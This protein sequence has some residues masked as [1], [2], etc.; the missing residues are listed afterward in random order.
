MITLQ[1]NEPFQH[2]F[3]LGLVVRKQNWRQGIGRA[4][5]QRV[6]EEA[7]KVKIVFDRKAQKHSINPIFQIRCYKVVETFRF[8]QSVNELWSV[9]YFRHTTKGFYK[10][11]Y[12]VCKN[13]VKLVQLVI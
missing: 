4:L 12:L 2:V 13:N 3:G 9:A 1:S 11:D 7:I 5:M 6:E 10:M 8:R